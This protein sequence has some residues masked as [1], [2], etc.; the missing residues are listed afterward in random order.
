MYDARLSR[1]PVL[2][3]FIITAGGILAGF[4]V[5]WINSALV[6]QPPGS[7]ATGSEFDLELEQVAKPKPPEEKIRR[8]P[9]PPEPPRPPENIPSVEPETRITALPA[10]IDLAATELP[11]T[12]STGLDASPGLPA[13]Y[14]SDALVP[15]IRVEPNYPGRAAARGLEGDVQVA[16]TVLADGS[17]TAVEV[18]HADPRGVF[19]RQAT[20]AIARWK[21]RPRAAGATPRRAT[22]TLKFRLPEGK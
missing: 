20:R 6:E 4:L 7:L 1:N 16:F 10:R 22:Q 18:L 15:L 8:N 17:V 11:G 19:E 2:S 9:E 13:D 5:F 21:F 14:G 3:K 12:V